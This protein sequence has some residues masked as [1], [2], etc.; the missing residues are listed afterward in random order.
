MIILKRNEAFKWYEKE[1]IYTKGYIYN[2]GKT[3]KGIE[4]C[5]FFKEIIV[6]NK[7]NMLREI[8]GCFSCIIDY[9]D[10]IFLISDKIASFPLYYTTDGK[11]I[12]DS[13]DDIINNKKIKT[14]INVNNIIELLS[15]SYITEEETVYKD[16]QIVNLGQYIKIC[17][18]GIIRS[19][20]YFKHIHNYGKKIDFDRF[21]GI[22]ILNKF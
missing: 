11:Y 18:N 12:S 9:K 7:M 5:D 2:L 10:T 19:N 8:N 14:N 6:N 13:I 21:F 20:Y 1:N 3:I 22:V 16:I 4:L 15:S 17:K